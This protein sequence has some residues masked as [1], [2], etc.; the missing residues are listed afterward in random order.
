MKC[1]GFINKPIKNEKMGSI[2]YRSNYEN[3]KRLVRV[4]VNNNNNPAPVYI[5]TLRSTIKELEDKKYDIITIISKRMTGSAHELVMKS[6]NLSVI[7]PNTKNN[8]SFI[9]ILSAIQKKTRDLCK[10]KCGKAPETQDDC[11][12]KIDRMYSCDIR[13]I[14][15]NATFHAKMKWKIVLLEDF[16]NL[17]CIEKEMESYSEVN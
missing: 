15:D 2:D 9:E 4:M 1:L 17:Y 8:F 3:R 12:G 7:T 11:S 5:D 10:N 13:R 14:S 6:S 16:Y